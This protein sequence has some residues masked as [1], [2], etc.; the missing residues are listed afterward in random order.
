MKT[1]DKNSDLDIRKVARIKDKATSK[2][3]EVIEFAVSDTERTCIELPP[4]VVNSPVSF[5]NELLD[6]GAILP[7]DDN[8]LKAL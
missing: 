5:A 7:K 8:V 2:F 6:A 1:S 4:S 3:L